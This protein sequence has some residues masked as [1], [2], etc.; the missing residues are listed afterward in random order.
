M[1]PVRGELER[2]GDESISAEEARRLWSLAK[3]RIGSD[4][5]GAYEQHAFDAGRNLAQ[6]RAT[7]ADVLH[8]MVV[9]RNKDGLQHTRSWF[10]DKIPLSEP[11]RSVVDHPNTSAETLYVIAATGL[12]KRESEAAKK[13]LKEFRRGATLRQRIQLVAAKWRATRPEIPGK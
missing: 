2:S 12:D 5:L 11:L 7:P 4:S 3:G 6:N 8:D 9:S 10:M 1:K 13:R